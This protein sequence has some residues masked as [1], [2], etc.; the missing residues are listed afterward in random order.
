VTGRRW[1][2]VVILLALGLMGQAPP[3]APDAEYEGLLARAKTDPAA[4]DF[5]QLRMA[6]VRSPRY[7]P[8]AIHSD[9]SPEMK[10]ALDA[11]DWA[12]VLRIAE[13][14]L[15][16]NYLRMRPHVYA[17]MAARSLGDEDRG[18]YHFRFA[19]GLRRAIEASGDGL[20]P[21][22]AIVL[23]AVEEEHDVFLVKGLTSLSQAAARAGHR[24]L[25]V[26]T[27]QPREGGAPFT[28]YFDVTLPRARAPV[29]R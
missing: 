26:H 5:G 15:E 3:A 13:T 12:A 19:D 18:R 23:I 25:D 20:G 11:K 27:V 9:A 14:A 17:A 22:T 24:E 28:L 21:D 8:Y 6:L 2:F 4:A 16:R 29:R 1:S 10:Q 7:E